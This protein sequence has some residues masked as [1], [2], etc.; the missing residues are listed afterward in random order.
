MFF[1]YIIM[2][3][4]FAAN[5][6]IPL[7]LWALLAVKTDQ[8]SWKKISEW[9]KSH[10]SIEHWVEHLIQKSW[11]SS[12]LQI[13]WGL[14][15]LLE[16]TSFLMIVVIFDRHF[17]LA[18]LI[19]FWIATFFWILRWQFLIATFKSSMGFFYVHPIVRAVWKIHW[20]SGLK[21]I[22]LFGNYAQQKNSCLIERFI[23][24]FKS[25]VKL[26]VNKICL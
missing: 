26:F 8:N 10:I 4:Y 2:I 15:S 24:H 25:T 9:S 22:E 19:H 6:R 12:L 5:F 1:V 16:H 7:C 11:K 3:F 14:D 17:V 13:H 20:T 21:L 18:S 23:C